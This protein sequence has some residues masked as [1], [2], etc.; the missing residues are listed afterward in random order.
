[1]DKVKRYKTLVKD[2]VKRH[3]DFKETN[4]TESDVQLVIDD[5]RGHYYL[6]DV[7]WDGM[8]RIH[9][10]LLHLDV[11]MDGKIWV[12]KDFTERGIATD[13][14]EADVPKHDIV[15]GFHSPFKRKYTDFAQ[16]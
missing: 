13:L 9:S 14:M 1:M 16:A 3:S 6:M 10:C 11:K 2:L 15:L 8:E 12:Q 7:G 5:K 4:R